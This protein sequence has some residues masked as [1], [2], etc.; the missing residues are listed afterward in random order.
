MR[1]KS[2]KKFSE[3]QSICGMSFQCFTE[4]EKVLNRS[5]FIFVGF[6]SNTHI[7]QHSRDDER[8]QKRATAAAKSI[9]AIPIQ[10]M[11]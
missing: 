2:E 9:N 5:S 4:K 8:Q 1:Q 7:Y 6:L 10:A 11:E 3:I